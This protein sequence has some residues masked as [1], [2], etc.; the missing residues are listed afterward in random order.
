MEFQQ[1]IN[2]WR[3]QVNNGVAL[4]D[5]LQESFQE[6]HN[7]PV[8]TVNAVIQEEPTW[9]RR[10]ILSTDL[11]STICIP[12]KK[13][14]LALDKFPTVALYRP[15]ILGAIAAET[16]TF[17]REKYFLSGM[18]DHDILNYLEASNT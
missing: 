11:K 1:T 16:D 15:Q 7:P 6:I 8:E 4:F 5:I 17:I 12:T 13:G 10:I 9:D 2:E 18:S 3:T 14:W